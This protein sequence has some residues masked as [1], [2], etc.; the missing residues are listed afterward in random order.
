[1]KR[2]TALLLAV[3]LCLAFI[4][5]CSRPEEFVITAEKITFEE[6]L[7]TQ[8]EFGKAFFAVHGDIIYVLIEGSVKQYRLKEDRIVFEKNLPHSTEFDY[9]FTDSSGTLYASSMENG[10]TAFRDGEVIFTYTECAQ[11]T[12]HPSGD[13]GISWFV[14]SSVRV[15]RLDFSSIGSDSI[16]YD[17]V[18]IITSLNINDDHIIIAGTT[19]SGETNAV[20]VYDEADNK[21]KLTM[22]DKKFGEPGHMG[23][24][25][26]VAETKN[27]YMALDANMRTAV[28]WASDGT[29]IRTMEAAELFGTVYPWLCT[30]VTMP[31]GSILVGLTDVPAGGSE[32]EFMIYRITGF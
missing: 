6:A 20:F 18:S 19:L 27:G 3:N 22:G 23:F 12:V 25:T 32:K 21:L 15:V 14:S 30:A 9:I 29:Y 26:A 8:D 13:W 7:L 24:V 17:E 16:S 1:M 28:F 10:F 2:M 31:D 4:S 11:L 5:G